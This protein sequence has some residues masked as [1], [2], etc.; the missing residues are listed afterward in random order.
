V[1]DAVSKSAQLICGGSPT[2]DESGRGRFFQPTLLAHCTHHMDVMKNESFGPLLA[3][4]G[5]G[6]DEEAV[7]LMNDS[8]YGLT[9]A[10]F[11]QGMRALGV[12][13]LYVFPQR[14]LSFEPSGILDP[15]L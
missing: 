10:L 2:A 8:N 11:T 6:S 14:C 5:V 13:S 15:S 7:A 12:I 9:A 1:D 4:Q 3:V